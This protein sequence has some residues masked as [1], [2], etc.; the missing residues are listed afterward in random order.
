[1]GA[2]L[3]AARPEW[4]RVIARGLPVFAILREDA[5]SGI[6]EV[7]AAGVRPEHAEARMDDF[8]ATTGKEKRR[9]YR[10][11]M[12]VEEVLEEAVEAAV[13]GQGGL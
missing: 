13:G 1:M 8:R 6:V 4:G 10:V 12:S 7:L 3:R 9:L 2:G 5:R 11:R